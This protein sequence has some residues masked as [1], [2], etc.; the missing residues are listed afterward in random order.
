MRLIF[1]LLGRFFALLYSHRFHSKA[2]SLLQWFYTGYR[3]RHFYHWGKGS[4]MGFNMHICGES[5]ID[6]MDNVYFGGDSALTAFCV[7]DDK[8]RIR[9]TIGNDC[10]FGND[11]HIT[12]AN[13]ITI[14]NGLRTG[15]SVLISDNAHGDPA[16]LEQLKMHPNVRP[17]YS[18]GP[19]VIGNNVWIG[20]KVA[21]LGGVKIGDGAIIGA[22]A[23][24]THDVPPYSIAVGCPAKIIKRND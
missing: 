2:N 21:V 14:G 19:I 22:N 11:C 18:K 9:I 7:D 10:M 5:M 15:K 1:L 6:V 12:C 3:T 17:L 4:K 8:S 24:V 16:K 23:V 20:D 13:S